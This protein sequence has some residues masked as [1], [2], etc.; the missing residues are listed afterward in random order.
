MAEVSVPASRWRGLGRFLV[1][2]GLLLLALRVVHLAVPMLYPEV[3]AGPFSLQG[4]EHAQAYTGFAPLAPSYHPRELGARPLHVTARRR[5]AEVVAFWQAE[6][7]LRLEQRQ[8]EGSLP[9][10]P[11]ARPL[12][13]VSGARWRQVGPVHHV[14]VERAGLTLTLATDLPR[15]D[16]ERLLASL[17]PVRPQRPER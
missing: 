2:L 12:A 10:H 6:R 8:G 7:F 9:A 14:S 1:S 3:L 16:L 5:P 13:G 4:L 11:D 15:R 17:H